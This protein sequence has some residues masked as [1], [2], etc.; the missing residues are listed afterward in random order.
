MKINYKIIVV[1]LLL[2]QS[3]F[4]QKGEV[5]GKLI[6]VDFQDPVAFANIL[7]KG[8]TTGTT[9]DFDGVYTIPLDEGTYTITYSFLGYKTVEIT[10]VIIKPG[11]VTT[12]DVSMETLAE[13]LDEVV[14][15]V[16][17]K[18][19]TETAVL[20][21]Q[22]KAVN[23]LDGISAETFKKSGSSN[24]AS[25]IK[26]VPG[27]SVQGGKY[28]YVRGLGD[29]YTKSI[30]NGVDIPGLDPDRN[31]IQLD[32]FPTNIID[33]VL[34]LK[35]SSAD[36]PADFTGGMVNIV[37]KD[38]PTKKEYS[39]SLSG[40]YNPDMHFNGDYL[41]Y[42]GGDSDFLGFDDGTRDV[43]INENQDIPNTYDYDP[44]LT[45]ITKQ[46]NPVLGAMRSNSGM[47]YSLGFTLGNQFNVGEGEN[48]L[49]FLASVSYKNSTT[50]YEGAENNF[51]RRNSDK[52]VFELETDRTQRGDIGENNVLVSGLLGTSFKTARSKYKLNLLHLQN[53]ESTAGVFNQTLN[54]SDFVNFAKDNIEYTQRSITNALLTGTHTSEDASWSSEW[55]LSPTLSKIE[56]KDVRTTSFQVEDGVYAIAQNNQPKR[57][58][59][60][61]EEINGVAKLDFTKKYELGQKDAKLKFGAY[62]SYKT[63][64][65][66]ILNFEIQSS[67]FPTVNYEGDANNI[68]LEEN[69][70]T[71]SNNSGSHIDP[72]ISISEPANTYEA[73]QQNIAGY[74]SNEFKVGSKLRTILGLRMEK[75]ESTYTG[76][77]NKDINDPEKVIFDNETIL[78]EF[79]FFPTANLIYEL[80]EQVNL[81]G[82]YART[83]ARPSFKE[84]S[85]AKIFD[86]LSSNTFIGNIN[87]QPTYINNFDFRIEWFGESAE[88][89][90][91]SS[92]YKKFKDPIELTYFESSTDN[93]QPQNLGDAD[94]IGLEFEV[95]KNL[96]FIAPVLSNLSFNVNTSIIKST[97]IYSDQERNLR[98]LG[99]RDGQTLGNDR[100]LQG[101]SPFLINTGINYEGEENGMQMG[102]F[103]NVQGKTLQVVGNG[104]VPDVYTMPYH[105]LNFNLTK[106]FG[107]NNNQSINF[108]IANLMNDDV[109]SEYESFGATNKTFSKRS[110]GRAFSIGYSIKF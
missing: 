14:V 16:S 86:P 72:D 12:V 81:R 19:N 91:L 49:G 52:S 21:I 109:E 1:T 39:L 98:E 46:F 45:T 104:F 61:L 97:Q 100:E 47:D 93:F 56:D 58:W 50:Y 6:D 23:V 38:Y 64:D 69:L 26:T 77:D 7:I 20:G 15:S 102:L 82:S 76:E 24:V 44:R 25:A 42:D 105:N 57:I 79:D 28:V 88:M 85:I 90:A 29:R 9:S 35:S 40:T 84:A 3:I 37:T 43:P 55:A 94:V 4:A 101:Q 27:V 10:D 63:R 22:K 80:T 89:I 48:R 5:T 65:F 60:D 2:V 59:R 107:E 18:K 75:F 33:N 54:F 31:T 62:G 83:T 34:V 71:V 108:K 95:R 99:L 74:V 8:T 36:L 13:G 110:P 103:Y 11:E 70:W 32:I 53:G 96:G 92:F 66:S 87:L 30:L 73:A 17:V 78:D 67:N 41:D 68:L 106:S 51:Y